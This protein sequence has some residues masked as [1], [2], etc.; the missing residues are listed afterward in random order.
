[1][2]ER[3]LAKIA[4]D[5]LVAYLNRRT[6]EPS[7]LPELVREVRAA[8]A[9]ERAGSVAP[10]LIASV[11]MS[12][13]DENAV[14]SAKPAVPIEESVTPDFIIC[15]EDGQRFRSL[16]RHLQQKYGL[17]PA[18]YRAKW[19]LPDDYPIVAPNLSERRSE[20][21]RSAGFGRRRTSGGAV[22]HVETE[23]PAQRPAAESRKARSAR[24]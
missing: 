3:D 9:G 1:M 16:K 18:A 5:I 17:S 21:A 12:R 15:L 23:G 10:A 2:V 22:E 11:P 4:G 24:G 8:I 7:E 20:Q 6:V 19:G 14:P 13:V